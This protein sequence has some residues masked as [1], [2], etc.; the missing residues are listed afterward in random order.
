MNKN[1]FIT[2]ELRIIFKTI[3]SETNSQSTDRPGGQATY[4]EEGSAV[5]AFSIGEEELAVEVI[6][7]KEA[8]GA[9]EGAVSSVICAARRV[10]SQEGV[11]HC[12]ARDASRISITGS[13]GG[14]ERNSST[15]C[16]YKLNHC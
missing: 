14:R 8:E 7:L 3:L 11:S 10:F 16:R 4:R 5:R 12:N 9:V 2:A 6:L 1:Y 13:I 15:T